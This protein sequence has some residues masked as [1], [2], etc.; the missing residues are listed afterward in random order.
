[1]RRVIGLGYQVDHATDHGGSVAV[2][3]DDPD[4]N[5]VE[6]YYDRP[7]EDWFDPEGRPVLRDERIEI[8]DLMGESPH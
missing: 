1:M 4:G 7:R 8:R 6:L 5:G 2:Y 3:L